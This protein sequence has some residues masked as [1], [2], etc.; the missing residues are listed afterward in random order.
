MGK[1]YTVLPKDAAAAIANAQ[2]HML[3]VDISIKRIQEIKK[4]VASHIG[5][6]VL[7]SN[8]GERNTTPSVVTI[9]AV[10]PNFF[11]VSWPCYAPN[12]KYRQHLRERY[13]W[14]D[15]YTRSVT[16]KYLDGDDI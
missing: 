4:E 13:L 14:S 3:D 2:S 5:Q 16:L 8:F 9:E 10:Y 7:L 15:L 1:K 11:T 6:L 12:G